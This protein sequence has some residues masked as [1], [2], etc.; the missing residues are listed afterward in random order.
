MMKTEKVIITSGSWARGVLVVAIAVALFLIRDLILVILASIVIA[1]AVE[2]AAEWA[3]KRRIPRLPT[4]LGLYILM[5]TA[6]A[7]LFYFLLLPLVGEFSTFIG[8]FPEYASSFSKDSLLG[9]ASQVLS[10]GDVVAQINTLL[11]SFSQGAF[12][13]ASFI[14]GGVLSFL[15]IVIL[16]FY[17]AVQ[18]DGVGK[19]LRM[20]TPWKQEKYVLDLW[21]RSK[22]KIALWMQ[23]QILLAAIIA[24][25]VYLGLLLLGIPHA[26]LLA[27][28]SGMLEIVPLF[29]PIIAAIPAV[30][31]GFGA[32]G[33]SEALLIAGLYLIVHQFEN[34]L[35]YPLV[36]KKVVGVPP[37]VS[38]VALLV[39]AKLAGFIGI[40]ISVP[41][42]AIL[43]EF[44]SDLEKQKSARVAASEAT[45]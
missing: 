36:V 42:A 16:S 23:G 28:A 26:L 17:L 21:S 14:F 11:I 24:V 40:V 18:E 6:F 3:K 13:S 38:I 44:I 37:M 29:G 34:Q 25:L 10:V 9:G 19:F 12:S 22:R 5:A 8:Q 43:M 27:V 4:I 30:V 45:L 41:L 32:G 15:L 39:G 2:P 31:V 35:I 20:V 1:S 7:G 33:M